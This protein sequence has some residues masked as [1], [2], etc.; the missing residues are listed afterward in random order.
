MN[1]PHNHAEGDY[2]EKKFYREVSEPRRGTKYV[3]NN[4]HYYALSALVKI[5]WY[6]ARSNLKW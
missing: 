2:W 4:I 5:K 3:S 6:K 1:S